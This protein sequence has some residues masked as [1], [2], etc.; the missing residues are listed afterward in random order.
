MTQCKFGALLRGHVEPSLP[1]TG[2]LIGRRC[3]VN[4]VRALSAGV[5]EMMSPP[6]GRACSFGRGSPAPGPRRGAADW[7]GDSDEVALTAVSS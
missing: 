4:V 1:C 7:K 6:P 5:D 2:L 3:L